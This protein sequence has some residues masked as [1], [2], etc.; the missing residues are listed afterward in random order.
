MRNSTLKSRFED[1]F[2]PEPNSGCWIWTGA[3]WNTTGHVPRGKIVVGRKVQRLAYRVAYELYVGKI[4]KGLSVCHKCDNP[5]CV[6]PSH[7]FLGTSADNM[8]DKVR[9]G[10][11]KAGSGYNGKP[12][13]DQI[14]YNQGEANGRSQLTNNQAKLI[15]T[16]SLPVSKLSEKYG[17]SRRVINSI[18]SRRSWKLLSS[19][20]QT[21][22]TRFAPI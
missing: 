4:A 16:S 18:K 11:A 8:R 13:G 3:V 22:D 6:N 15:L 5:I 9:K 2:I 7:L 12:R 21:C 1:K 10:R 19:G 14:T 17:V 20:D